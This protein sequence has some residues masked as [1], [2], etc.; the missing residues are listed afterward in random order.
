[1]SSGISESC[2]ELGLPVTVEKREVRWF[3]VIIDSGTYGIARIP[4]IV[5]V[6]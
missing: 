4:L 5:P 1:M 3:I 6:S 2:G